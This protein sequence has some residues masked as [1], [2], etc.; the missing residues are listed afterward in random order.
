MAE[1]ILTMEDDWGAKGAQATGAQVQKFIKDQLQSLHDKDTS[2]QDQIDS[3][4][5]KDTDFKDKIDYLYNEA[6]DLRDRV[7]ELTNDV[8]DLHDQVDSQDNKNG[9]LQSQLRNLSEK[10]TALQNQ[11]HMLDKTSQGLRADLDPLMDASAGF[12]DQI[13]ALDP[14]LYAATDGCFV[15]FTQNSNAQQ[16]A[17]PWWEWPA[18]EAA[19]EVANG[20]L[21]LIDG[22]APIIVSPTETNLK[23]SED[24]TVVNNDIN[25]DFTKAYVDYNGKTKTAAIMA[26]AAKLFGEDEENWTQYA[27]AWCNAYDRRH[28]KGKGQM[29]G[30]GFGKWWLP[31]IAELIIIWKHKYAIN[32]CL[33]V[34]SGASQLSDSWYWSS[35]ES[36]APF[37]WWLNLSSGLIHN[38][39]QKNVYRMYVRAVAAFH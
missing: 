32:Q 24:L 26:Q 12:Q 36:N 21:V 14:Q 8:T 2:L 16:L 35:T 34:I 17:V 28:D 10:D 31:S 7:V 13:D 38:T 22:Q 6:E 30:I 23:W 18:K 3:L 37:A 19:G 9:D 20:V 39:N 4:T 15:T 11:I 25:A 27:P 5:N 33:S 1:K 29:I